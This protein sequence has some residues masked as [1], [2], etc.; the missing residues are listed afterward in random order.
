MLPT[1]IL[2]R[3]AS[4]NSKQARQTFSCLPRISP[5][6][7]SVQYLV[8]V[9]AE[10]LGQTGTAKT[11]CWHTT[12][13]IF[14][15]NVRSLHVGSRLQDNIKVNLTEIVCEDVNRFRIRYS[16]IMFF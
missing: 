6:V 14:R 5:G 7:V 10:S 9:K 4:P 13:G 8:H 2:K 1:Q 15:R 3:E 12:A 11:K 16:S